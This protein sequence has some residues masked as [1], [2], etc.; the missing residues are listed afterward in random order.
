MNLG[1]QKR[2]KKIIVVY[3]LVLGVLIIA[4]YSFNKLS[5]INKPLFISPIGKVSTN[6]SSVEKILKENKIQFSGVM[7][8]G[9]SYSVQI[10]DGLVKLSSD[11]DIN[12]QIASLQRILIQLTIE[13]KSY[14]VIDFRFNE[15]IISF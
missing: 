6:V 15:P 13:G 10:A 8:D 4:V 7:R 11:K 1:R 14:K 3:L 2:S 9:N 12:Q 5:L